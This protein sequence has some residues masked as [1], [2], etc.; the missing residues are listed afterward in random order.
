MLSMVG[1]STWRAEFRPDRNKTT[2]GDN[3]LPFSGGKLRKS[4][5]VP[6]YKF[7]ARRY[8]TIYCHPSIS[9]VRLDI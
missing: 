2:L 5:N 9:H 3:R 8:Y 4:T 6:D 7:S 1:R